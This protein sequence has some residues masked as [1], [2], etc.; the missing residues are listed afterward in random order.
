MGIRIIAG[1]LRGR[2]LEVP[3]LPGLRPTTDRL[4]E[5]IFNILAHPLEIDPVTSLPGPVRSASRD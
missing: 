5:T 3:D 1:E 4:R 2:R